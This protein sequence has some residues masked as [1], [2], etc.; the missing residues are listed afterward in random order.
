MPITS[1]GRTRLTRGYTIGLI[2]AAFLST[3]A[4]FI[5]YLTL[6]Y[7][8]PP[9]VMAFWRDL[10]VALTLL[11]VL[12]LLRPHL[13]RVNRL[14]LYYLAGFGLVLAVFNSLWTLSV[15][16][17]GA[18][19]ATVLAYSSAG[20]TAL[21]GWWLLKER[22]DGVKLLAVTLSLGGCVLVSGALNPAVWSTNLAGILTGVF[23]G[24][25]YAIYTLMGRSAA[26]RG[27]NPWTTLFYTF[28]F[29]TVFLLVFNLLPG[30]LLPGA[31]NQ[32]GDLFWLGNAWSGWLVLF[33]LAAG[34]TVAGF[35][36][37]NVSLSYLP[38]SVVNLIATLEPAFTAVIAY[39]LFGE[40]LTPVQVFGS[41][42]ILSGVV[43]LRIHEGRL[44]GEA[45][46]GQPK[47]TGDLT[48]KILE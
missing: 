17:N 28:S 41:L 29:A 27:L 20:F 19:V 5:R 31:A 1:L 33:L 44:A 45:Q 14:H 2:S 26:Q 23:S 38:S 40:R 43:F 13:L 7:S 32:P 4:I 39:F 9:L 18:S 8:L 36:L 16:L 15:A 24:L 21:L 30:G 6:T 35:G 37:Y 25:F 3:T 10:F 47:K 22:L 34:P 12:G 48:E 46:P 11:P 42:M